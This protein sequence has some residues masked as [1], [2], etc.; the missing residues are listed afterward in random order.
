MPSA[1]PECEVDFTHQEWE[2]HWE[3]EKNGCGCNC[4]LENVGKLYG[5]SPYFTDINGMKPAK[6]N[7]KMNVAFTDSTIAKIRTMDMY[8]Q[9]SMDWFTEIDS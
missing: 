2:N 1:A 6:M 4:W 8:N 3:A 7:A 5:I 9:L